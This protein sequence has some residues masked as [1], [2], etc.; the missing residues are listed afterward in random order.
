MS[1]NVTCYFYTSFIQLAGA[2]ENWRQECLDQGNVLTRRSLRPGATERSV[3]DATKE[4]RQM[5]W[6]G[7][8]RTWSSTSAALYVRIASDRSRPAMNF[9]MWAR[10]NSF[11]RKTT[12]SDTSRR[13]PTLVSKGKLGCLSI[14]QQLFN[15]NRSNF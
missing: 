4:S 14:C 13:S 6:F 1:F 5:T 15:L 3:P 12:T 2:I 9:I 10:T 11:V 8:P 7:G